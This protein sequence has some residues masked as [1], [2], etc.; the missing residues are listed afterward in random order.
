MV[1]PAA[2]QKIRIFL[3]CAVVLGLAIYLGAQIG[4]ETY[5]PLLLGAVALIVISIPLFSGHYF[6]VLT[7]ASS[8]L[9]GTFPILGGQF[10]P[11]QILMA[12]GVVKFLIGDVV[13]KHARIRKPE[14]F[15]TLLIAGFMAILIWHGV[16]DRFG[17]KFLGSNIWGGRQYVNVFV[18]LAAFF[19]ILTVPMKQT[20]WTKL[21][22]IVLAVTMFDLIIGIITTVFPGSIYTIYPFYSAVSQTGLEELTSGESLTGRIGNFGNFG[23]LLATW[24]LASVSLRKILL[25]SNF[26]RFVGLM[27][28]VFSAVYSGFRSAVINTFVGILAAGIRDLRLAV[29]ALLPVVAI[30]L[31]AVSFV[32]SDVIKLP[33]QVQ[34]SLAFIPG[35]WDTDMVLD[36]EASNDFRQQIWSLWLK[37]YFPAHPLIGRGFGFKSEWGHRLVN[38]NDPYINVQVVET[39]NIH[40]GFLA[41][42]DCF[43]IVG[44]ILFVLWNWRLLIRTFRVPSPKRDPE[45]VTLRFLGIYLAVSIICYWMG[46]QDVGSFLPREFAL[47]AVFIRLQAIVSAKGEPVPPARREVRP[48]YQ[49]KAA[50][51]QVLG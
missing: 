23:F 31:F 18:G 42:L 45:A 15:D 13:L 50:M 33:K 11:F 14:R 22:H 20:L 29:I 3:I 28:G 12:I 9:A 32:N 16:L 4:N 10:T 26:F 39:G 44:T 2:A 5:A 37:D 40:N 19:V 43:G 38:R 30:L 36:V 51:R 34:R 27:I 8:F 17:M 46:A 7:I 48:D 47:A 35:K 49:P 24:V 25:P 21:P 6:W 1:N 41:A